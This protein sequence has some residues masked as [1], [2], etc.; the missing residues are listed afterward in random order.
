MFGR[1]DVVSISRMRGYSCIVVLVCFVFWRLVWFETFGA[2]GIGIE[3][4]KGRGGGQEIAGL[5]A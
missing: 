1:C 4:D 5:F 2:L 3:P